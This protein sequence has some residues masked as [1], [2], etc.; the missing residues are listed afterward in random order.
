[1]KKAATKVKDCM[2]KDRYPACP[3][4]N[5]GSEICTPICQP[6]CQPCPCRQQILPSQQYNEHLQIESDPVQQPVTYRSKRPFFPPF[7]HCLSKKPA[8]EYEKTKTLSKCYDP[9][10]IPICQSTCTLQ[11]QFAQHQAIGHDPT[12]IWQPVY[13]TQP[14]IGQMEYDNFTPP[15]FQHPTKDYLP[16]NR[17]SN[18]QQTKEPVQTKPQ[19]D[20]SSMENL[21]MGYR[22][23]RHMGQQSVETPLIYRPIENLGYPQMTPSPMEPRSMGYEPIGYPSTGAPNVPMGPQPIGQPLIGQ[24]PLVYSPMGF[25]SMCPSPIGPSLMGPSPM[26]PPQMYPQ[27]MGYPQMGAPLMSYPPMGHPPIENPPIGPPK[28]HLQMGSLNLPSKIN[29][30]RPKP[31]QHRRLPKRVVSKRI[32]TKNDL[33]KKDLSRRA[34][35]K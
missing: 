30:M 35:N 3:Y 12:S 11:P 29:P 34:G 31:S 24:P 2:S 22:P 17:P 32:F 28:S 8:I 9:C 13:T 27:P 18:E 1:M 5:S 26:G 25:A 15:I 16:N 20:S 19:I 6:I 7:F 33:N 23:I 21:Q 14:P 4:R 10:R